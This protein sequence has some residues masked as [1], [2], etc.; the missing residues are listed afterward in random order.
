MDNQQVGLNSTPR[1]KTENSILALVFF[2][3]G[4]L[5]LYGMMRSRPKRTRM[6]EKKTI[7]SSFGISHY[8]T[9]SFVAAAMAL[10]METLMF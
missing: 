7:V 8:V 6:G 10:I 2:A 9:V 4:A 5:H 3:V 1:A